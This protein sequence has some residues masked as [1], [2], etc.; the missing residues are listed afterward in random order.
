MI[1]LRKIIPLLFL[2][3]VGFVSNAQ[4]APGTQSMEIALPTQAGDTLKLSSLTGKI[5]LLDFWASWC[6]PCRAAN[7]H[8]VKLYLKYKDKGFEILSVSL[9]E[10][11]KQWKKAIAK[12][13]MS[14]LHVTDG[15]GFYGSTAR[16]W[17]IEAIPTSYLIN[18]EGKLVAMDLF[19]KD[20]ENAVKDLLAK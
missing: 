7:K 8:L 3:V 10:E 20:L 18:K 11:D 19:G 15:N 6:G 14:W 4:P 16:S 5:V 13:K 2:I 9:D 1:N 12:D 17:Q